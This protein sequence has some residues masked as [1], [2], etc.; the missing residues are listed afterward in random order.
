MAQ[1]REKEVLL[2]EEQRRIDDLRRQLEHQLP[3]GEPVEDSR[4][5]TKAEDERRALEEERHEIERIR[6]EVEEEKT[7]LEGLQ[8]SLPEQTSVDEPNLQR[9]DDLEERERKVLQMEEELQAKERQM[10]GELRD[11]EKQVEEEL[12]AKEKQMEEE[13][14]AKERQMEELRASLESI[15]KEISSREVVGGWYSGCVRMTHLTP[16]PDDELHLSEGGDMTSIKE[17]G[18]VHPT[19]S[20]VTTSVTHS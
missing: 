18:D 13:L 15:Q 12:H 16:R 1:Q 14:L 4:D 19:Y 17:R 11:K 5:G 6:M 20:H 2:E 3:A 10:E 9:R 8:R 7:R